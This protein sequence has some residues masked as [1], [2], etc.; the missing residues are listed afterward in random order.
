MRT[1]V[2]TGY[3]GLLHEAG[4]QWQLLGNGYRAY[5]PAL[6]RFHASDSMSPFGRGGINAYA[7]CGNDAVNRVD[8]SGHFIQYLPVIV[9]GAGA[10]GTAVWAALSKDSSTK[11]GLA[12]VAAA[13]SV[14][15]A[16]SLALSSPTVLKWT[17]GRSRRPSA[18]RSEPPA[19][20]VRPP[21]PAHAVP[22]SPPSPPPSVRSRASADS[23]FELEQRL[24]EGQRRMIGYDAHQVRD[25]VLDM[26]RL[27]GNA[28]PQRARGS[29]TSQGSSSGSTGQL[30][31]IITSHSPGNLA[32][33]DN[34]PQGIS[35]WAHSIR[36]DA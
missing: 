13:L 22:P 6:M 23:I 3:N 33:Q 1:S 20:P 17:S 27:F 7:Y 14:A 4:T 15:A 10:V 18:A 28:M 36:H 5:N 12:V 30:L 11:V 25:H 16:G 8:P 32:H 29:V 35:G 9:L 2:R 26:H 31:D 24:L 21:S 19:V 34:L